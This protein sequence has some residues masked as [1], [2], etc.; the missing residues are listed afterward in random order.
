MYISHPSCS[1]LCVWD[2]TSTSI[3]IVT[4]HRASSSPY[5]IETCNVNCSNQWLLYLGMWRSF[6]SLKTRISHF[7]Q[8]NL[9]NRKHSGNVLI[10]ILNRSALQYISIY[11]PVFFC[12]CRKHLIMSYLNGLCLLFPS[13]CAL[14]RLL[15][16]SFSCFVTIKK[17]YSKE[18]SIPRRNRDIAL[19]PAARNTSHRHLE[20][21][22]H[23]E[24]NRRKKRDI[25]AKVAREQKDL[26]I[27]LRI[28]N[29]RYWA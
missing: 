15:P 13:L 9:N 23:L 11:S 27:L 29:F 1:N 8:R 18:K 3:L 6:Y 2:I 28:E 19:F 26:F 21:I 5:A 17:K 12:I 24:N 25:I 14:I 20:T 16:V 22:E 7:D 4:G 10:S